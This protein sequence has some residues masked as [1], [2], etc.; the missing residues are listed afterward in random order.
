VA[1]KKADG[2]DIYLQP[3]GAAG[4]GGA[5]G[6][7]ETPKV[8]FTVV[9]DSLRVRRTPS[10]VGVEVVEAK[11]LRGQRVEVV[12]DSRTEADG[13]VWWQHS[14]GWSAEKK[15]GSTSSIFM[16][17]LSQ[18]EGGGTA[19]TPWKF[20]KLPLSMADMRWFYYYGN[21]VFA[22]ESGADHNYDGY[23]QG[24]H[25]GLDLGHPGGATVVAGVHGTFAGPGGSFGPNRVDVT[26]GEHRIVYGH[27]AAPA[28]YL[29]GTPVTPDTYI[30]KID[31]WAGH[32][33]IEIRYQGRFILNPLLFLDST[34][35]DEIF[36]RFP[37]VGSAAFYSSPRWNKWVTPLDQPTILLGGPLI[38]PRAP[39]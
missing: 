16:L 22:F 19:E 2:S 12:P 30:G 32:V 4:P 18:T 24:L 23:S 33:H 39:V 17:R 11:L 37:A 15:I 10:A 29:V 35:R 3:E 9:I 27:L 28:N 6:Q 14:A 38:G 21:T 20:E 25:G 8:I 13:F 36:V 5:G 1:E 7:P 26:I 31:N 34:L